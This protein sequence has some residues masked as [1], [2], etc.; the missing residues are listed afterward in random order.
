MEAAVHPLTT[1]HRH[2]GGWALGSTPGPG[3]GHFISLA[4]TLPFLLQSRN[5]GENSQSQTVP[6]TPVP[7][8]LGQSG[9]SPGVHRKQGAAAEQAA[10]QVGSKPTFPVWTLIPPGQLEP[11]KPHPHR[12]HRWHPCP[13]PRSR[14]GLDTKLVQAEPCDR[15]QQE[16]SSSSRCCPA[17][18]LGGP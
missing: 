6:L 7:G 5:S 2:L 12:L 15:I 10:P 14:Q 17:Q 18:H 1:V 13:G 9:T 8:R 4:E 3:T 11:G 16:P